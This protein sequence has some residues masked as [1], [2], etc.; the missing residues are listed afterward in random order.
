M[1]F[2]AMPV[3]LL[4]IGAAAAAQD[5]N[6]NRM[7][8]PYPEVRLEET[9]GHAPAGAPPPNAN[10]M[11]G[12]YSEAPVSELAVAPNPMGNRLNDDWAKPE[13]SSA[14]AERSGKQKRR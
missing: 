13:S 2:I 9:L 5:P 12:E 8:E 14:Q 11:N 3:A 10:R 6:R 1:K 4:A 7:N